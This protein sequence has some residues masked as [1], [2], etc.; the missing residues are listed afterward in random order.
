M[1]SFGMRSTEDVNS[2]TSRHDAMPLALG[3]L[4]VGLSLAVLCGWAVRADRLV[5]VLPARAAMQPATA[6]C[7]GCLGLALVL[8]WRG[9]NGCL[10]GC[11]VRSRY[12][13]AASWHCRRPRR[14]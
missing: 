1:G 8:A 3:I 2:W 11:A 9:W 7:L 13:I 12:P 4:V 6:L 5:M 10:T 14:P